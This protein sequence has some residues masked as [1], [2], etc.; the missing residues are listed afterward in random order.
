MIIMMMKG[1][2][3]KEQVEHTTTKPERN[4]L[5]IFFDKDPQDLTKATLK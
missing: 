4:S 3:R 2:M 1:M 5:E